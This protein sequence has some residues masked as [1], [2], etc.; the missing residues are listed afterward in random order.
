MLRTS[1][2]LGLAVVCTGAACKSATPP[3]GTQAG[4]SARAAQSKLQDSMASILTAYS[5]RRLSADSAARL[6][7]NLSAGG[8]AT[9]VELDSALLAALRAEN[10]RRM[11]A[12]EEAFTAYSERRISPDSAAQVILDLMPG[13]A[14]MGLESDA[15]LRAALATESER[16]SR[17]KRR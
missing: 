2:S 7:L 6:M 3:P 14:T 16:R 15:K 12:L 8:L 11:T 9:N 13:Y 1:L 17:A 10:L 4:D 5:E